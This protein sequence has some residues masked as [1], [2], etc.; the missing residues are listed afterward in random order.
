MSKQPTGLD[1]LRLT[2]EY[3][4]KGEKLSNARN[5]AM[6]KLSYKASIEQGS[7]QCDMRPRRD[8]TL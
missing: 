1:L 4:H 7:M 2:M 6:N 3:I 5:K 8:L